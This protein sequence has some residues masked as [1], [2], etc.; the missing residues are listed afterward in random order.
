MDGTSKDYLRTGR[1]FRPASRTYAKSVFPNMILAMARKTVF[2]SALKAADGCHEIVVSTYQG[3]VWNVRLEDYDKCLSILLKLGPAPAFPS[4]P[5]GYI[6][7]IRN[8]IEVEFS[9]RS[10][11]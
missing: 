11:L 2:V 5:E 1:L 8:L 9:D 4:N 6:D 10:L 3:F 7:Q